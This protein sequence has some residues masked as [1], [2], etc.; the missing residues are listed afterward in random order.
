VAGKW[1]L[2]SQGELQ[3]QA[4]FPLEGPEAGLEQGFSAEVEDERILFSSEKA[5]ADP[6]DGHTLPDLQV[7]EIRRNFYGQLAL[8]RAKIFEKPLILNDSGEH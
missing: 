3:V 1:G 5:Q 8:A 4:F 7:R 2:E 6:V